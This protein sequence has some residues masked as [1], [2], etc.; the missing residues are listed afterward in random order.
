MVIV[1][2]TS[3]PFFGNDTALENLLIKGKVTLEEETDYSN[4][5]IWL[6]GINVKTRTKADG[7]FSLQL[8]NPKSL[9]GGAFAWN[10]ELPLYFY[11]DNFRIDSVM[12]FILNGKLKPEQENIS[13]SGKLK[14]NRNLR[15]II[16]IHSTCEP[17]QILAIDSTVITVRIEVLQ[18]ST[19]SRLF[20]YKDS[21]DS[22]KAFYIFNVKNPVE[23]FKKFFIPPGSPYKG[24]FNKALYG[25]HKIKVS[26]P[27]GEYKIMPF[28]HLA[29]A[30]IPNDM[31]IEIGEYPDRFTGEY[32]KM[33]FTFE[34]PVLKV[35]LRKED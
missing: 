30:G 20:T 5:F 16:R 10:G 17:E 28:I 24:F 9:P 19:G 3:N 26:L 29:Q 21:D 4:V 22:L 15:K 13:D 34:S 35:V 31:F 2:C 25:E 6:R 23:K 32:L 14:T 33:P 11:M 7:S 8:P 27:K 12:V 1:Y 18:R